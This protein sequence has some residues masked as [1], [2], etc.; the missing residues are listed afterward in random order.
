MSTELSP[1]NEQ[2][3]QQAIDSGVFANRE[4]AMDE[5][6]GLLKRRVELLQQID[7]GLEQLRKGDYADYDEADL[8]AFFEEIKTEGRR[9]CEA[10]KN[11][12]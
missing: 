9:E 4:Q 1:E 5:A 8:K 3:L 2:F 7:E 6:V 11:R 10:E 12:Q